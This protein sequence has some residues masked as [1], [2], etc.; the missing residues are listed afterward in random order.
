[1]NPSEQLGTKEGD[2]AHL[3][4]HLDGGSGLWVVGHDLRQ[5]SWEGAG[6]GC[7]PVPATH[8]S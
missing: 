4:M 1:M 6:R 5:R 8:V 2:E 7:K 3:K